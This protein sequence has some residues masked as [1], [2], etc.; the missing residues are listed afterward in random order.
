MQYVQISNIIDTSIRCL[1]SGQ[2][3]AMVK[4]CMAICLIWLILLLVIVEHWLSAYLLRNLPLKKESSLY[5]IWNAHTMFL[6]CGADL[7]SCNSC[8][9]RSLTLSL[10]FF[11]ILMSVKPTHVRQE[12]PVSICSTVIDAFVHLGTQAPNVSQ[13]SL[14]YYYQNI[15]FRKGMYVF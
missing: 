4:G 2:S 8:Y 6:L 15:N 5:V 9:E 12:V 1:I 14:L 11:Q 3:T 7:S 13:V 10:S